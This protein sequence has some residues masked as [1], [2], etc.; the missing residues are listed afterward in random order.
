MRPLPQPAPIPPSLTLHRP[1]RRRKRQGA[2]PYG[3]DGPR[4]AFRRFRPSDGPPLAG[5]RRPI[6]AIG[7]AEESAHYSHRAPNPPA[8]ARPAGPFVT[9]T[10]PPS[11]FTYISLHIHLH[12]YNSLS[13]PFPTSR[14][15][16]LP[17]HPGTT[18]NFVVSGILCTFVASLI[19]CYI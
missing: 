15:I 9:P 6:F 18:H 16:P 7:M 10:L 3:C 11:P 12:P 5:V 13:S 14:H 8:V 4:P 17:F 1:S 19:C 2:C